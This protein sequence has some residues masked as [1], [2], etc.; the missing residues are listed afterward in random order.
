MTGLDDIADS[1]NRASGIHCRADQPYALYFSNGR[2][3]SVAQSSPHF[4]YRIGKT[5]KHVVGVY[6]INVDF[7]LIVED[8]N[9]F[10]AEAIKNQ[11]AP[12][13]VKT[14]K[15]KNAEKQKQAEQEAQ[16]N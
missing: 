3:A 7:R 11:E 2:I 13:F 5:C 12:S 4:N 15:L 10:Y 14:R 1:I 8:I 9:F 6:K 16:A